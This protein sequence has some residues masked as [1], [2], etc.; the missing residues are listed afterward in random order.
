MVTP[1]ISTPSQLPCQ[2]LAQDMML[3]EL[4]ERAA[5]GMLDSGQSTLEYQHVG[6]WASVRLLAAAVASS[7]W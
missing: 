4:A 7:F 2:P 3:G 5:G 1:A 6:V